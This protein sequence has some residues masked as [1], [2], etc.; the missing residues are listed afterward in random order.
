MI[1]IKDYKWCLLFFE[2]FIII[3]ITV[4]IKSVFRKGSEL[5]E[6]IVYYDPLTQKHLGMALMDFKS[7]VDSDSFIL[8]HNDKTMMGSTVSCF[9]DPLGIF[10][11]FY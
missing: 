2:Y 10:H 6:V 9:Y 3:I 1:Y 7:K 8:K 11:K 5:Y 4:I